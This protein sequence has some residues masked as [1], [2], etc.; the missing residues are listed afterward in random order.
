MDQGLSN[1]EVTQMYH[2]AGVMFGDLVSPATVGI[3]PDF[4][5]CLEDW[6][7]WETAYASRGLR[8]VS[9]DAFVSEAMCQGST[10]HLLGQQRRGHEAPVF[11]AREYEGKHGK[12]LGVNHE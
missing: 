4:K 6:K 2:D 10:D 12:S 7:N 11:Y 1:T 3:S 9:L 5:R 8:T